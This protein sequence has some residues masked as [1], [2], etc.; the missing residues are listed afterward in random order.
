[1][2]ANLGPTFARPV[3]V[4]NTGLKHKVVYA[5]AEEREQNRCEERA[6]RCV[7]LKCVNVPRSAR[8]ADQRENHSASPCNGKTDRNSRFDRFGEAR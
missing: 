8:R 5:P 4:R 1:M 2:N 7:T 3:F 6:F